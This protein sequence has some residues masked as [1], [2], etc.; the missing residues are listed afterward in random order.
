MNLQSL[1]AKIDRAHERHQTAVTILEKEKKALGVAKRKVTAAVEAQSAVQTIVQS[2]QHKAHGSIAAVVSK[3]LALIFDDPYQ[4]QIQ[5]DRKRGKTEAKLQ[6]LRDGHILEDPLE[7][8]GGGV[9]DVASFALRVACIAASKPPARRILILDEP[10]KFVS[11]D[12]RPRIRNMIEQLTKELDF[13][14]I[15][16]THINELKIGTVIKL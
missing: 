10:F 5:F 8:C 4:F 15:M 6:F 9:L 7:E 3:C 13:Q 12:L 11:E 14:I 16:V 1:K 2:V